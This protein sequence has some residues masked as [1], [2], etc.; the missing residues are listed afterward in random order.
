MVM[1]APPIP[2]ELWERIT[3]FLRDAR[4]GSLTM[5]IAH[6]AVSTLEIREYIRA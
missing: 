4:T 5:H 6:G 3:A 1:M 2:R